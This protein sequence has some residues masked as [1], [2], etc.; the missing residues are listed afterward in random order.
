MSKPRR[1]GSVTAGGRRL[2]NNNY[3]ATM[4]IDVFLPTPHIIIPPKRAFE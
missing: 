1:G 3:R 2:D 4:C